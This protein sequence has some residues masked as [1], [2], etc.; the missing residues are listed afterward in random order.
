MEIL[1]LELFIHDKQGI[2]FYFKEC[3]GKMHNRSCIFLIGMILFP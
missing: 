3:F 2:K 1:F